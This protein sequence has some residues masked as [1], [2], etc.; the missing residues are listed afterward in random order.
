MIDIP[1]PEG[2]KYLGQFVK[3]IILWNKNYILNLTPQE[4]LQEA[5]QG[6]LALE[7]VNIEEE[8]ILHEQDYVDPV[9]PDVSEKPATPP[10]VSD[11][12]AT[13]LHVSEKPTTPPHV[14]EKHAPEEQ[15][16]SAKQ[17]QEP[18][19]AMTCDA[20]VVP[21]I[22]RAYEK[23][24]T[25]EVDMWLK[26]NQASKGKDRKKGKE[27]AKAKDVSTKNE[28][29]PDLKFYTKVIGLDDIGDL[30]DAPLIYEH[31]KPFLPDFA[32]NSEYLPGEMKRFHNW[33]LRACK[34]GV[35]LV[36]AFIPSRCFNTLSKTTIVDFLEFHNMFR[37]G[38]V[39]I[40]AMI[41][42]CMMQYQMAKAMGNK[43]T[44]FLDP[45]IIN[46]GRHDWPLKLKDDSAKL[47][48][49]K[50]KVE[51]E[52]IRH[53]LHKQAQREVISYIVT[54][55]R[56]FYDENQDQILAPYHF[57]GHWI[58]LYIIP[59][60]SKV[61]VFDSLDVDSKRY[62]TIMHIIRVAFKHAMEKYGLSFHPQRKDN[63][64]YRAYFPVSST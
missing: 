7:H 11:K 3:Q 45:S 53:Q 31:G 26:K 62:K 55:L 47:A 56:F 49:G 33:Y 60:H 30:L 57:D 43:R 10:D 38:E 44:G 46:Q 8:H 39:D 32:R 29:I 52:A 13:P 37:L 1:T 41:L 2:V 14:S 21:T 9:P 12:P 17:D 22:V 28:P 34:L 18:V 50:T 23:A 19:A 63:I 54:A 40:T 64:A 24:V 5:E 16:T 35:L 59:K 48:A 6:Q 58:C 61:V 42:W 51:K 20:R 36:S 25:P 4:T 27:P 15:E